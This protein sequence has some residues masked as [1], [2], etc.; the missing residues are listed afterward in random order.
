MRTILNAA[1][2]VCGGMCVAQH[3][4]HTRHCPT[5]HTFLFPE[6]R[7]S[8]VAHF[9][10]GKHSIFTDHFF[11][12]FP[13]CVPARKRLGALVRRDYAPTESRLPSRWGE[14][15]REKNAPNTW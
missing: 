11:V 9:A 5:E 15:G 12:C 6:M 10:S 3:T 7:H 13:P 4:P 14:R 8:Q 2:N 1:A